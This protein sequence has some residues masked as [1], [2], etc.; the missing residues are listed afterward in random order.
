[1]PPKGFPVIITGNGHGFPVKPVLS[2]APLMTVAEN[3][4][5]TPIVISDLGAPFIVD[6]YTPIDF[7]FVAMDLN[8]GAEGQWVGYSDGGATRPQ[9][10][11]GTVNPQPTAVTT[12]LAFY[13]DTNSGV[14]LAV[15]QGDYESELAGLQV[16]IGGF[17]MPS[18]EIELISGNTWVRLSGLPGDMED[19]ALYQVLFGFNL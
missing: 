5:G 14:F 3:G 8:A 18:F 12:L 19:G 9:P 6:G 15:F 4:K 10:A 2:N 16:S 17:V 11:F 7:G 13:D 1:M